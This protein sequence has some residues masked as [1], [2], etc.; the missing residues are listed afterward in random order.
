[1]CFWLI[2]LAAGADAQLRDLVGVVFEVI[3]ALALKILFRKDEGGV[4]KESQLSGYI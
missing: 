1:M 3:D 2:L 4:L